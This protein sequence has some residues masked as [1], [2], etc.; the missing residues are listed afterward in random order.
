MQVTLSNPE[1]HS[2]ATPKQLD[3]IT[4]ATAAFQTGGGGGEDL[5]VVPWQPAEVTPLG[6][7]A[8]T[9]FLCRSG[10]DGSLSTG[11]AEDLAIFDEV[12]GKDKAS[13]HISRL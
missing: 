9:A 3:L 10:S 2:Q 7:G 5:V 13:R 4:E 8:V 6:G 1:Q 11:G 12:L